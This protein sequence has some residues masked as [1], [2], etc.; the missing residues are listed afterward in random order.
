VT[1]RVDRGG[2]NREAQGD[3]LV[4]H[5]L[6]AKGGSDRIDAESETFIA[7]TLRGEGFDASED[8]TGRGTPLIAVA[9]P[10]SAGNNANSNAAGRR[11]EDDTNL[12][13]HTQAGVR[14]LTP[15]ECERL[16]GFDD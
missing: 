11:R 2:S 1:T 7:H 12:V 6:N 4:A 8:G 5:C 15:R 3:N 10:L 13:A 14:R 16:Q 9:A